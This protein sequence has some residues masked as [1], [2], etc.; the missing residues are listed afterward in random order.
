MSKDIFIS[1]SRR[2][3]EFV[4]RLASD[5]DAHVAGVW[6]DQSTIQAGQKW[7]DEIME[8]IH[9]CKAFILVLSPDAME[10]R[11]VREEIN[12]ALEL[13]KTVF[14][15][16]Y[17]PAKWTGEFE[18]LVRDVQTLD[19]RSG[20]YTENFQRLVDGLIEAGAAKA[21]GERPF[22]RQPTKTSLN[23]VLSKIPGWAFAWSVGW[24]VFGIVLLI[25]LT[26]LAASQGKLGREDFLNFILILISAGIG[27]FTGGLL[28]GFFTMLALRPNAPSIS[29]KHMS[30]AI[31]IWGISG[32]LGMIVSG[33]ITVL[34]V[35]AGAISVQHQELDCSGISQCIGAAFG[36]AI[37]EAIGLIILVLAVFL[38][39]VIV[40]WFLDRNV[41][42][43]AGSP[44]YSQVRTGHHRKARLECLSGLGLRSDPRSGCDD[45]SYWNYFKRIAAIAS[46]V[47]NSRAF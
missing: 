16:I 24:V 11:Y 42:R 32:P 17:R 25:F 40:A 15:V 2:D 36:S 27:G 35:A 45:L 3:Q 12:K 23:I 30:P 34:M 26:I 47:K 4:T 41:C 44:S 22:L 5:L 6:F 37:G 1:Y 21:V 14:P 20:S 46:Q 13:G 39:F 33:G 7:H 10:S 28:A 38:L 43:M 9:E 8:G 19:L 31:R 29:W 18:A